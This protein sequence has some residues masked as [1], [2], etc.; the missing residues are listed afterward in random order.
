MT[1]TTLTPVYPKVTGLELLTLDSDRSL[2]RIS[3]GDM[4]EVAQPLDR[5]QNLFEQCDGTRSLGDIQ[6]AGLAS[7][8]AETIIEALAETDALTFDQEAPVD[9]GTR[10]LIV[11]CDEALFQAATYL[12]VERFDNVSFSNRETLFA[13]AATIENPLIAVLSSRLDANWFVAIDTQCAA[14]GVPW[15]AFHLDGGRGWLGPLV[16]PQRTADYRDLLDRRRCSGDA[17]EA[18]QLA[19]PLGTAEGAPFDPVTPSASEIL[20]MLGLFFEELARAEQDGVCRLHSG[21]L[22][23]DPVD[24]ST[25]SFYFLPM[26]TRPVPENW[27]TG[28]PDYWAQM[29]N[30][31]GG[32]VLAQHPV[33]HHPS[34]PDSL[35]TIQSHCCDISRACPWENDSFVGGSAF[36]DEIAARGASLGE[37]VERYCGNFI[38]SRDPNRGNIWRKA[39]YNELIAAGEHAVDPDQLILYSDALLAKEG[40]PFTPFTR[41][42]PVTWVAGRSIT[43]D[44]PA[45]LPMTLT[46]A[47][48]MADTFVDEPITNHLYTPGM[49]GGRNLEEALVGAVREVVER[50]IT[51]AWWLNHTALP[52][53]ELTPELE[54]LWRGLPQQHHQRYRLLHLDN[55]FDIPVVVGIVEDPVNHFINIGFGCRPDPVEAA[56][57]AWSEAL[58]LQEGSRDLLQP[59]S[60]LRMSAE[61]WGMLSVPYLPHRADRRYLDSFDPE[62]RDVT[63]LMLQQQVFLDPR[64][65]EKVRPLLD[66]PVGRR[67]ADLPRLPDNRFATYRSRVEA[68]GFEI[69][70]ADITSSDV[71]LT[72]MKAVRVIIPGLIPNMPA[73]FPAAGG[74]RVFDLPVQLGWRETPLR[75]DQ[76]NYFP[77]P[78]A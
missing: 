1:D 12:A 31:R 71:A 14:L 67:F 3:D 9:Q 73:A 23:A 24:F 63:D 32:I 6:V 5:L 40:C 56:K 76:L 11:C 50:D 30:H 41:D 13:T 52:S 10:H 8:D 66:T 78:H 39:S 47:N 2:V 60:L 38:P 18:A 49:A 22:R 15:A 75:E 58:T 4:F 55:P 33:Q 29:V 53:I 69:F 74:A 57:K 19:E 72:G 61:E 25:E 16:V 7:E 51:M 45:W 42:L 35:I 48:W 70:Y 64:A 34:I 68:Q 62:F 26:P 77:M 17:V 54:A 46:Y 43:K 65:V 37:A 36:N 28:A 21:E 59:E 20:W 27:L 44:R